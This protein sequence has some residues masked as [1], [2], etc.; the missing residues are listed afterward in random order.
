[1]AQADQSGARVEHAG[2]TVNLGGL[3][4]FFEGKGRQ[5]GRHAFRKHGFSGSWRADHQNVM[6]ASA[7]DFEGALGG[8]LA[9]N[10]FEIDREVLRLAEQLIGVDLQAGNAV[11]GIDE[12]NDVEQGLDGVNLNPT[13]HGSFASVDF[14]HDQAFHL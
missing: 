1:R 11:A 6:T 14:G 7:G 4:R 13:D 3:E 10:V 12:M 2:H 5:D 8:L 9:A